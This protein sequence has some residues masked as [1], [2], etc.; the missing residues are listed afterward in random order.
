MPSHKRRTTSN[1]GNSDK[2]K[3]TATSK[4]NESSSQTSAPSFVLD[5][6]PPN[7]ELK[8]LGGLLNA[9][10]QRLARLEAQGPLNHLSLYKGAWRQQLGN[11]RRRISQL[12]EAINAANK[13][14][15]D[16]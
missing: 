14:R 15:K 7:D 6:N 11:Q 1:S 8:R 9:A 10:L 12:Q 2:S 13:P 16:S 4:N 3:K 5:G